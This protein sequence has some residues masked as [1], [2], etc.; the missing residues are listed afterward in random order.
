[1]VISAYITNIM[2]MTLIIEKF[3]NEVKHLMAWGLLR[4]DDLE[5]KMEVIMVAKQVCI[6]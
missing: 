1:M 2:G 3:H 4:I 5:E 6:Y